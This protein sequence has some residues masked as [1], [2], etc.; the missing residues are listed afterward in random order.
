MRY[1]RYDEFSPCAAL[2][3]CIKCYWVLESCQAGPADGHGIMSTMYPDGFMD[4]IFNFGAPIRLEI[5]GVERLV[6]TGESVIIGQLKQNLNFLAA[7][8]K[9]FGVKF[10]PFGLR[11]FFNIPVHDLTNNV[12]NFENIAGGRLCAAFG[13]RLGECLANEGIER[14]VLIVEEFFVK[15]MLA[16]R[17]DL[18]MNL[19]KE[20]IRV[21]DAANGLL[22]IEAMA[23]DLAV[24]KRLLEMRFKEIVG[25]SPKH[26]SGIVRV[27]KLLPI[28]NDPRN[29][30]IIDN[31]L[32]FGYS[33][34]S[35]FIQE[36]KRH[37]GLTPG[38]FRAH[39]WEI[40]LNKV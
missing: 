20:S 3:E 2:R 26:Y 15:L 4:F 8:V 25:I 10:Y 9:F 40:E 14:A 16:G 38:E 35:H 21:I 6:S 29:R 31:A 12:N 7:G 28:L 13:E 27:N 22:R 5:A 1:L 19:I 36:F 11:T 23:D 17:G 33:S 39:R 24:S 34:Q 30:N 32:K 37:T 18:A